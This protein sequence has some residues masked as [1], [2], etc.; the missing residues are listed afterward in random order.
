MHSGNKSD[1]F[2]IIIEVKRYL[3]R[4]IVYFV[5][6]IRQN[7]LGIIIIVLERRRKSWVLDVA[8]DGLSYTYCIEIIS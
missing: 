2:F 6:I 4:F 1:N 3:F 8:F 7:K 5:I